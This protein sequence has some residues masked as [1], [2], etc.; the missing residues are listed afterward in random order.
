MLQ[1]RVH[2]LDRVE[3]APLILI[4]TTIAMSSPQELSYPCSGTATACAGRMTRAIAQLR[5]RLCYEL[6]QSEHDAVVRCCR[7]A[8]RYTT[9]PPARAL[10]TI[11]HHAV[12]IRPRLNFLRSS[13]QLVRVRAGR[14]VAGLFATLRDVVFDWMVDAE[15]SY[16]A[17]LLGLRRGL[18]VARLLREVLLQ[19]HDYPALR[20]CDDLRTE[21]AALLTRAEEGLRWFAENPDGALSSSR[22]VVPRYRGIARMSNVDQATHH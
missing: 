13:N 12:M 6:S 20:I 22:P 11:V 15:R 16:R 7:E 5:E 19:Q 18:D 9:E 8:R 3:N 2:R 4:G 21:R 1:D 17:T 10:R 14:A